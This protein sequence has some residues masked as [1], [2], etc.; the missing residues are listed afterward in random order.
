[1]LLVDGGALEEASFPGWCFPGSMVMGG[2]WAR[3]IG[4]GSSIAFCELGNWN[5]V[6]DGN[7]V[8]RVSGGADGWW[9]RFQVGLNSHV[10]CVQQDWKMPV[11]CAIVLVDC[12]LFGVMHRWLLLATLVLNGCCPASE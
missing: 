7:L 1:M 3:G 6:S 9:R 2:A 10:I 4:S 8:N 5:I 12:V 11:H